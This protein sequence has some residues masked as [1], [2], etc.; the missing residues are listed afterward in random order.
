MS[1]PQSAPPGWLTIS[2]LALERGV[3]KSAM[4]RRVARLERLGHLSTRA[5]GK[6]KLVNVADFDRA[7]ALTV[8]A[9]RELNGRRATGPPFGAGLNGD[10]PVL[11][12]EQARR[13]SY[14]AELKRLDLE[15]RQ[16]RLVELSAVRADLE[17]CVV[18]LVR[19]IDALPS[20]A[21]TLMA[22]VTKEGV[23][24]LRVA[25]RG[26]ARE[27]REALARAAESFADGEGPF[28]DAQKLSVEEYAA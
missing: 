25:L 11:A 6:A 28:A 7:T 3:D 17:S 5:Q 18:E 20:R 13:A 2:G 15:E 26:V 8:D 1:D 16:G 14:D 19:V 24:G 4:S 10:D 27:W 23:A 21:D 9:V 12:K 22:A